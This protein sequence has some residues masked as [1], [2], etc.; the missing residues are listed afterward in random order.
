M[1]YIGLRG[2]EESSRNRHFLH[3]EGTLREGDTGARQRR[4]V[5]SSTISHMVQGVPK[6]RCPKGEH[7]FCKERMEEKAACHVCSVCHRT[8][9]GTGINERKKQ[10]EQRGKK[11]QQSPAMAPQCRP[12][13]LNNGPFFNFSHV[14][15]LKTPKKN[16]R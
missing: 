8:E 5:V 9:G 12:C 3:P 1:N 2:V 13:V 15:R 16:F 14:K 7:C 10:G 11:L 6:M 4:I